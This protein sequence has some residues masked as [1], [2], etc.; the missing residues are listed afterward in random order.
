MPQLSLVVALVTCRVVRAPDRSVKEPVVAGEVPQDRVCV[1][2]EPFTAQAR[3]AGIELPPASSE[4]E[5]PVPLGSG[6]ESAAPVESPGPALDRVTVK[7]MG[8]PALTETAS[9]VLVRVS[10]G[11]L[12]VLVARDVGEPSLGVLPLAVLS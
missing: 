1:G 2:A 12:A 6:A 9:W 11:Q 8:L 7:P 5:T 10:D 3:P 4:H